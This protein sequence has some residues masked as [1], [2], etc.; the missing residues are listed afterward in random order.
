MNDEIMKPMQAKKIASIHYFH[1]NLEKHMM[2]NRCYET[3][4]TNST[5]KPIQPIWGN[6]SCKKTVHPNQIGIASGATWSL[7]FLAS[8]TDG[9]PAPP[10]QPVG[11]DQ[12]MTHDRLVGTVWI[13]LVVHQHTSAWY[14]ILHTWNC[15]YIFVYMVCMV[16]TINYLDVKDL[17]PHIRNA[18]EGIL[19]QMLHWDVELFHPPGAT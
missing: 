13:D 14:I 10:W 11:S 9:K 16:Y 18:G 5:M 19:Q 4:S 6:I 12:H 3:N 17:E 1:P 2:F 7:S 8:M 15:A